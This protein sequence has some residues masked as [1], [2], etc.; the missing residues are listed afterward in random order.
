[1]QA[2]GNYLPDFLNQRS[3]QVHCIALHWSKRLP[4]G[5]WLN[6]VCYMENPTQPSPQVNSATYFMTSINVFH[7]H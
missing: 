2:V 5:K 7:Q 1:M 3:Q 4:L 6:S